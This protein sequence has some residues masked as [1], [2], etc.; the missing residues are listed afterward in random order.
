MSEVNEKQLS[1]SDQALINE[2]IAKAKIE[3]DKFFNYFG[4]RDAEKEYATKEFEAFLEDWKEADMGRGFFDSP[5]G[6]RA[7]MVGWFRGR[8]T[9][10]PSNVINESNKDT[11]E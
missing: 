4:L 1:D 6:R 5:L 3:S 11:K 10:R 2:A 7:F 8:N 9:F